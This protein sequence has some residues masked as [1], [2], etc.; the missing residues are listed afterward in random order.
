[1]DDAI[2]AN[3][4]STPLY[5]QWV[6]NLL[7]TDMYNHHGSYSVEDMTHEWFD[8]FI[9]ER[10]RD[11][12]KSAPMWGRTQ[13][14]HFQRIKKQEKLSA[15]WERNNPVLCKNMLRYIEIHHSTDWEYNKC[16]DFDNNYLGLWDKFI[17]PV[18]E[19]IKIIPQKH[20]GVLSAI[21]NHEAIRVDLELV[22][23]NTILILAYSIDDNPTHVNTVLKDITTLRGEFKRLHDPVFDQIRNIR[24]G[25]LHYDDPQHIPFIQSAH[26]LRSLY[27]DIKEQIQN[28]KYFVKTLKT[29]KNQNKQLY[30]QISDCT[31]HIRSLSGD[32]KV[33]PKTALLLQKPTSRLGDDLASS[34]MRIGLDYTVSATVYPEL[35][36]SMYLIAVDMSNLGDG[37]NIFVVGGHTAFGIYAHRYEHLHNNRIKVLYFNRYEDGKECISKEHSFHREQAGNSHKVTGDDMELAKYHRLGY[38]E[39]YYPS[40]LEEYDLLSRYYD[41][42]SKLSTGNELQNR[43]ISTVETLVDQNDKV[44][45]TLMD[46]LDIALDYTLPTRLAGVGGIMD[47]SMYV[48]N[49]ILRMKQITTG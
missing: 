25:Y 37:S 35:P 23:E 28:I 31:K 12:L 10:K 36:N 14:T 9:E 4:V 22:L 6:R 30:D 38:T 26:H 11:R 32:T 16:P 39:T 47:A 48:D 43:L 1:M 44:G 40:V 27:G 13:Q 5:R 33:T 34:C 15:N 17:L 45:H 42:G 7:A 2:F 49:L 8:F 19:Q 3:T 41:N 46:M 24:I 18:Q 20:E 29:Y 21:I